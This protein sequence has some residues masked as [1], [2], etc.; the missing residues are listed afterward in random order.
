MQYKV[1]SEMVLAGRYV[2][3]QVGMSV[4][5]VKGLVTE[6]QRNCGR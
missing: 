1:E 6:G 5:V 4:M 2:V 3:R